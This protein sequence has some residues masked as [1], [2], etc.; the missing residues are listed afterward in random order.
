[1]KVLITWIFENHSS[2]QLL[3]RRGKFS[4]FYK[5]QARASSNSITQELSASHLQMYLKN[6]LIMIIMQQASHYTQMWT[7]IPPPLPVLRHIAESYPGQI[8]FGQNEEGMWRNVPGAKSNSSITFKVVPGAGLPP[9]TSSLLL[10]SLRNQYDIQRAMTSPRHW[11]A[12]FTDAPVD[13]R[14]VT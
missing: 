2:D 12:T 3:C 11:K 9:S 10:F 6:K 8:S 4:R 5:S 14:E 1:M 13:F 7:N